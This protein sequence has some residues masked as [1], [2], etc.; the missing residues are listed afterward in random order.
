MGTY[1]QAFIIYVSGLFLFRYEHQGEHNSSIHI[2]RRSQD[3]VMPE[4]D[5]KKSETKKSD[6]IY[7]FTMKTINIFID[8]NENISFFTTARNE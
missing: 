8:C 2:E 5:F 6:V 7:T 3:D 4:G 1:Y